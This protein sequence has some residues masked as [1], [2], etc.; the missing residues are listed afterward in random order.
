MDFIWHE[1]WTVSLD[2][3]DKVVHDKV[4]HGI[5]PSPMEHTSVI[6]DDINHYFS[7]F[8][9]VLG[10]HKFGSLKRQPIRRDYAL[11]YT[12]EVEVSGQGAINRNYLG[13]EVFEQRLKLATLGL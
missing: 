10:H 2:Y 3:H 8:V 6:P 1:I 13:T 7:A 4:V 12:M 9:S 5:D 11:I